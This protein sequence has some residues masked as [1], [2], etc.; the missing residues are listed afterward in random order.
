[1]T[2]RKELLSKIKFNST[3]TVHIEELDIE[4]LIKL[5]PSGRVLELSKKVED[6]EISQEELTF[7]II[8]E[9]LVDGNGKP[10]LTLDEVKELSIPILTQLAEE[11]SEFN[12]LGVEHKTDLK[13]VHT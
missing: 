1:M 11:V 2:N 8:T 4:V 10:L 13:K 7:I 3:K 6:E 5:L 12:H 9:S